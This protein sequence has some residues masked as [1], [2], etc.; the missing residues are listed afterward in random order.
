MGN[1]ILYTVNPGWR[2][3]LADVGIDM[4][5]VL[6]RAGLPGDL[7][8]REKAYLGTEEYFCLW[9]A[10]EEEA[11][12]P[13]LPL[14]L[15]SS[16][17]VEV[18]DPPIFAALCSKDLNHALERLSLYKRLIGPMRLDIEKGS[19]ETILELKWLDE[20]IVPPASL[21][22]MELA[23]FVQLCR[24]A[25]RAR[26]CP[27]EVFAPVPLEPEEAYRDFFGVEVRMGP[28]PR[29][30]FSAEDAARPFLTAN[31]KML[32]C[33]EPELRKSLSELDEVA[34]TSERVEAALMELLPGGD[35]AINS[36]AVKLGY[37]K[38]TLQRRLRQEGHTFQLLLNRTR[39]RLAKHYLKTSRMSGAEISFLLGFQEPNSFFR[40]FYGWMGQT[41]EQAR[42]MLRQMN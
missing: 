38:R 17:S 22:A 5:N 33:F 9:R 31:R 25:T 27:R 29:I 4:A 28:F 19:R 8:G 20:T 39:S 32:E 40:A 10:L 35:P 37:S 42:S 15:G 3:L 41:P 36:V 6:R 21:V 16:I 14:R 34:T 23:F 12:D 24:L 30:S 7:F 18:F 1:A 13:T 26:V 2:I 11:D